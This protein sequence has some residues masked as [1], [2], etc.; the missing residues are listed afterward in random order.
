MYFPADRH[1]ENYY[2]YQTGTGYSNT[3]NF[4]S[5]IYMKKGEQ[6]YYKTESYAASSHN[7][8]EK[9][10]CQTIPGETHSCTWLEI[11]KSG[12]LTVKD[13]DI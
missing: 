7:L 10:D 12:E 8:N 2:Y 9:M 1:G 11:R 13:L 4:I 3:A 5:H 6:A